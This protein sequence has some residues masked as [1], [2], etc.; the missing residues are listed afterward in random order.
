MWCSYQDCLFA[1]QGGHQ[2][3]P[4]GS[5]KCDPWRRHVHELGPG[6]GEGI[7]LVTLLSST[8]TD[9]D[10]MMNESLE[11]Q[12]SSAE[13]SIRWVL[14]Q[15]NMQIDQERYGKGDDVSFTS[16]WSVV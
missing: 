4:N 2:R 9:H 6:N 12:R 13:M 11:H 7:V 14:L 5:E 10:W 1:L 16:V 3:R 8:S 15:A